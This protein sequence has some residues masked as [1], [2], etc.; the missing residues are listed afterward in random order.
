MFSLLLLNDA[1]IQNLEHRMEKD[2]VRKIL[3]HYDTEASRQFLPRQE[4]T[5]YISAKAEAK[6]YTVASISAKLKEHGFTFVLCG[7]KSQGDDLQISP[8]AC[9]RCD[10]KFYA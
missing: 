5:D 8:E 4:E 1:I 3:E 2:I 6:N 9:P 10:G 7:L